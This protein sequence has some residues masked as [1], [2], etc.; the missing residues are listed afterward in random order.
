MP[1]SICAAPKLN[2][3]TRIHGACQYLNREKFARLDKPENLR[4]N[5]FIPWME[6]IA[7]GEHHHSHPLK[8]RQIKQAGQAF[9]LRAFFAAQRMSSQGVC[10]FV[11]TE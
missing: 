11:Q 3:Y 8:A 10:F 5:Q 4:Y 6:V 9:G 7:P 2:Y 1:P